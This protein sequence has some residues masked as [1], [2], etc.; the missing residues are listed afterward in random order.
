MSSFVPWRPLLASVVCAACSSAIAPRPDAGAGA[1][2]RRDV[3]VE[4]DPGVSIA[5]REVLA[6]DRAEGVPVL[7]VHGAGGGGIASFDVP[8]PGYSLAEDLARA[9][10]AVYVLD[11][12]GW[13]R[14][15]RP[16]A[17]EAPP[18]ANEPLVGSAEA[19]RD[20]AAV[21][22]RIRSQRHSAVALVGWATGGHWAGMYAATHA[23]DVSHLVMLNAMYGTPGPWS[24][25]AGLEDADRP[26]VLSPSLGAYLVRRAT[27][28]V[29]GWEASIPVVDR[30]AWRDPRVSAAY[31]NATI[32]SDP[33]SSQR[34]PP[35][36]RVPTGPLRDSYALAGGT[37]MWDASALR[38]A[39]LVV[40]GSLDFWSR[41]EDLAALRRDLV[42]ARRVEIIEIPGATHFV[43]L[44]RPEHGRDR[45][46]ALLR[47][48]LAQP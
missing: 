47:S 3:T 34:E 15:T 13:G 27:G 48:F 43:F 41:P 35:S 9:G 42:H 45:L 22:A 37:R 31:V 2:S 23:D 28:L 32:A 30:D 12:R 17:M 26:G 25:R 33:T 8:I 20:I 29:R 36:V 1:V 5:V 10:H 40:R 7:L 24:L 19:V 39:V 11:V 21:V 14:S 18:E 46:I 4:S 16:A 38:A 6:R 44:D